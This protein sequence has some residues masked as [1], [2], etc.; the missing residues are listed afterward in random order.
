MAKKINQGKRGVDKRKSKKMGQEY[1]KG[2]QKTKDKINA[3][4]I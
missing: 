2:K 1:E 4:K 3:V